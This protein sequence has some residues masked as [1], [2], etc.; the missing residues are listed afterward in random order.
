MYL[1]AVY[2]S[3]MYPPS[4]F[5]S[6]SYLSSSRTYLSSS[7]QPC[8]ATTVSR[9]EPTCSAVY[10]IALV[11]YITI[12]VLSIHPLCIDLECIYL[13]RMYLTTFLQLGLVCIVLLSISLYLCNHLVISSASM[14]PFGYLFYIY[15]TICS[16]V[17]IYAIVCLSLR[18]YAT[19]SLSFYIHGT[20]CLSVSMSLRKNY[21]LRRSMSP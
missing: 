10:L 16:S 1:F 9:H 2:L 7:T 11:M 15:E 20:I 18:I 19:I 3:G 14:Q 5:V 8:T 6:S 21:A 4:I 17:Y 13:S 12:Y